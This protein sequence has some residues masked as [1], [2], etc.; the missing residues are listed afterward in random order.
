[1]NH[2]EELL[3]KSDSDLA[4]VD[5]LV[6]NVLVAKGIS[7]LAN[8]EIAPYCGLLDEGAAVLRQKL[9]AADAKFRRSPHRWKNDIRFA[10]LTLMCWYVDCVLGIRY[11]ED[12]RNLRSVSYTNPNDLF[13]NGVLQTRRGTCANMAMAYVALGWRM[14]WPVSLACV[15]SHFICRYD[16]GE[17]IHNIEASSAEDGGFHSPPDEHYIEQYR[18]P[19]KAI[20]CGSDLRA[21]TP[22][23]MLGVFLGFRARHLVDTGRPADAERDYLLARHLFPINR[24]LAIAQHHVS[25]QQFAELFEPHEKGDPVELAEG[26]QQVAGVGGCVNARRQY[27]E[28]YHADFPPDLFTLIDNAYASPWPGRA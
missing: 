21:I 5:P 7:S 6:M 2:W 27:R 16:D 26:L 13:L 23:E 18:L 10:R 3:G 20:R 22:R 11:R 25:L 8:T 15:G 28:T 4:K 9:P 1:M 19:A 17:V 14:G 24:K 12:Q